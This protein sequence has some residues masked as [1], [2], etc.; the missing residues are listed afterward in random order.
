MEVETPLLRKRRHK[1]AD[2]LGNRS[3]D[4]ERFEA[5]A[6]S[7]EQ[8]AVHPVRQ[9]VGCT[10]GRLDALG[11]QPPSTWMAR[12]PRCDDSPPR[13]TWALVSHLPPHGGNKRPQKS[14]TSGV[15]SYLVS[16]WSLFPKILCFGEPPREGSTKEVQWQ[17]RELLGCTR[18]GAPDSKSAPCERLLGWPG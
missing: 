3:G 12:H 6:E 9:S 18:L 8:S 10:S 5:T 11:T 14:L 2:G 4:G 13:P 17:Q 16:R 7:N 15:F 1:M